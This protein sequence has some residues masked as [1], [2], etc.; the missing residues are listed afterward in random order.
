M[1]HWV[2]ELVR[3]GERTVLESEPDLEL[4]RGKV[5][6]VVVLGFATVFSNR[7]IFCE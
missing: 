1:V 6:D 4:T 2:I 3:S 5:S 7:D